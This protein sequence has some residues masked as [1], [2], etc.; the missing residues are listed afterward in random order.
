MLDVLRQWNIGIKVILGLVVLSFII[1]YA[2]NFASRAKKDR[3][4]YMATVGKEHI[5]M[6]EFQNTYRM[7]KQQSEQM[8][9]QG[10]EISP[11][12]ENFFRQ[13][14]IQG[15]VDRKLMLREA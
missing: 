4:Q 7:V 10:R 9:G 1:F 14:T 2:G 8:Y 12:M 6:T 11:E 3:T 13:Q 15:L 5:A